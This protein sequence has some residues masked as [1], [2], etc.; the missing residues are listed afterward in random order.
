MAAR[1]RLVHEGSPI[2][3]NGESESNHSSVAA[4]STR[5]SQPPHDNNVHA[6]RHIARCNLAAINV[7]NMSSTAS[8]PYK[9]QTR[10]IVGGEDDSNDHDDLD[11]MMMDEDDHGHTS[12]NQ[13]ER[14][15]SARDNSTSLY[16]R[17][18][19]DVHN[20]QQHTTGHMPFNAAQQPVELQHQQP[21]FYNSGQTY[22]PSNP[23]ISNAPVDTQ[24]AT[25]IYPMPPASMSP[26][27]VLDAA[28]IA[29]NYAESLKPCQQSERRQP[30]PHGIR[31]AIEYFL[32]HHCRV[33]AVVPTSWYQLKPRPADHYHLQNRSRGDSDAKMVTDEVEELRSL[34]QQGFLVAC[35]PGDD[36]DAYALALARR[37]DDRRQRD[38][39]ETQQDEPMDMEED[40]EQF[41]ASVLGGY[42]VSNDFFQDAI[43]RDER[44]Q[45]HH[46]HPLNMRPMSLK[47][48]LKTK[49]ISYSFANVGTASLEGEIRLEFLPNPRNDLIEA[50]DECNRL[51]CGIR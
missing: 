46:H 42:V 23:I 27:V 37:E 26:L 50:I 11:L 7:A 29:Y 4:A 48:W 43:R 47:T 38:E 25:S 44:K 33:Q 3:D 17:S 49:R 10:L 45:R 31:L 9:L 35:P 40:T 39:T 16:Y 15:S 30:N 28:N 24:P 2:V 6:H 19:G 1:P 22:G 32:K 20:G 5:V 14:N 8:K 34:R 36:D 18:H 21:Q 13:H 51:K 12:H 41:P